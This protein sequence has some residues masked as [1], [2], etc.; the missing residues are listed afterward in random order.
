M[1]DIFQ[2]HIVLVID[3]DQYAGNFE[4]QMCA[5]VTG[6]LG[7]CG[8]GHEQAQRFCDDLG[9][10]DP[11]DAYKIEAGT[12]E[13]IGGEADEHGTW[14]PVTIWPSPYFWNDGLGN[15]HP[16]HVALDDPKAI[17][18]YEKTI[19]AVEDGE[20][21]RCRLR[22]EGPTRCPAYCSVGIFLTRE[23]SMD[24]LEMWLARTRDYC[25]NPKACDPE[26]GPDEL[27]LLGFRVVR[28][29]AQEH[30]IAIMPVWELAGQRK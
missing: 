6:Y 8:V 30:P 7:D 15:H 22:D 11:E 18:Q 17:Q 12:A 13:V 16:L 10:D 29:T 2:E 25:A 14:R 23:P 26:W 5:Y 19:P 4:R 9:V 3:T 20:V 28:V 1:I 21:E 27:Q 24:E